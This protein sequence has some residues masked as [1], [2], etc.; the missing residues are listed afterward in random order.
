MQSSTHVIDATK[1]VASDPRDVDHTCS[2]LEPNPV[3]D[4]VRVITTPFVPRY[5]GVQPGV[6][7]DSI[8]RI[9]LRIRGLESPLA[10][11]RIAPTFFPSS[12]L[13]PRDGTCLDRMYEPPHPPIPHQAKESCENMSVEIGKDVVESE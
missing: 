3:V 10:H 11:R 5:R 6:T 12:F 13:S 4:R 7:L 2:Y 9:A 1:V 8:H